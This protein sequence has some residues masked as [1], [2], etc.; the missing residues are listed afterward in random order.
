MRAANHCS[1]IDQKSPA[2]GCG[3]KSAAERLRFLP[4]WDTLDMA[5]DG[6]ESSPISA[7]DAG[8]V[9]ALWLTDS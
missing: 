8:R 2:F 4:R 6:R 3:A 1:T 5:L 9:L 7:E